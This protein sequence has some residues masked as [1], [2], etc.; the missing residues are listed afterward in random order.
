MFFRTKSI[1]RFITGEMVEE[2]FDNKEVEPNTFYEECRSWNSENEVELNNLLEQ[3]I[4]FN[5]II[6]P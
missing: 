4:I 5:K 2:I 3:R 6:I 1:P